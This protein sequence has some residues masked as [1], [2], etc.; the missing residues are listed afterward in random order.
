M[1]APPP[2]TLDVLVEARRLVATGWC[3]HAY[4]A[5]TIDRAT[6]ECRATYCITGALARA[7]GIDRARTSSIIEHPAY[8]AM[9][10]AAGNRLLASWNDSADQ[11]TVLHA[12][13]VAIARQRGCGCD[14]DGYDPDCTRRALGGH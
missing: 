6:G 1:S 13:D 5:Q 9:M 4:E 3:T 8:R 7:A 11:E 10:E 14:D 12:I 2:S